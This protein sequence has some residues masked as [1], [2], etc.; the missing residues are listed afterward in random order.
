MHAHHWSHAHHWHN[1][2][3]SIRN[4]HWSGWSVCRHNPAS[5][6]NLRGS[7]VSWSC[8][9]SVGCSA[10]EHTVGRNSNWIS[11]SRRINRTWQG[12]KALEEVVITWN[13][14]RGGNRCGIHPEGTGRELFSIGIEAFFGCCVCRIAYFLWFTLLFWRVGRCIFLLLDIITKLFKFLYLGLLLGSLLWKS[15]KI[16]GNSFWSC[17]PGRLL[18]YQKP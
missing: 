15:Y 7:H 9:A 12:E 18:S 17:Q 6:G 5:S 14:D 8:G 16:L 13:D 1:G 4:C 3:G 2:Y 11:S 10:T